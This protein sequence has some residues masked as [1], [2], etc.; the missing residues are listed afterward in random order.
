MWIHV[1]WSMVNPR[2]TGPFVLIIVYPTMAAGFC[3]RHHA[4]SFE[5]RASRF[6][7]HRRRQTS[8]AQ[9]KI[10]MESN[11]ILMLT[12]KSLV[13][14]HPL[15]R[16]PK[17]Q[18]K[19][20]VAFRKSVLFLVPNWYHLDRHISTHRASNGL[21]G[22]PPPMRHGARTWRF[23]GT[24]DTG[25]GNGDAVYRH[26]GRASGDARGERPLEAL[27]FACCD[28]FRFG[29]LHLMIVWEE[30]D[31]FLIVTLRLKW[32]CTGLVLSSF[33]SWLLSLSWQALPC[34]ST[35]L[36]SSLISHSMNLIEAVLSQWVAQWLLSRIG[37][38]NSRLTDPRLSDGC[39]VMCL[40]ARRKLCLYRHQLHVLLQEACFPSGCLTANRSF[41]GGFEDA[42]SFVS[43][44]LLLLPSI[45]DHQFHE[46]SWASLREIHMNKD[47]PLADVNPLKPCKWL[48][49]VY[50]SA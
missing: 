19:I 17:Y 11:Q 8:N 22:K 34:L 41:H 35:M 9:L 39:T 36:S 37:F 49:Q 30:K 40:E 3:Y 50:L 23:M 16:T 13:F 21:P 28:G 45:P 29:F 7:K 42:N 1:P 46:P 43:K 24:V 27:V 10:S 15:S 47:L 6:R 20:L 18:P 12:T 5:S 44:F 31:L 48:N 25:A 26:L 32:F 33:W 4:G 38:P 2:P 14:H